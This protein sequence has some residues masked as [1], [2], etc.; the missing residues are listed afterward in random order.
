MTSRSSGESG[1]DPEAS[2]SN[3]T[4]M[5]DSHS[6]LSLSTSGGDKASRDQEN[7]PE[8]HLNLA[9]NATGAKEGTVKLRRIATSTLLGS[10]KSLQEISRVPHHEEVLLR[11]GEELGSTKSLQEL[12]LD[13]DFPTRKMPELRSRRTRHETKNKDVSHHEEVLL[14]RGEEFGSK[15]S[16]QDF[17]LVPV[18]ENVKRAILI[19]KDK[20][21]TAKMEGKIGGGGLDL[22]RTLTIEEKEEN[23]REEEAL[24]RRKLKAEKERELE[25]LRKVEMARLKERRVQRDEEIE[26]VKQKILE[27]EKAREELVEKKKA[28]EAE[29]RIE[30]NKEIV[31]EV[32]IGEEE[33]WRNTEVYMAQAEM[34][35]RTEE[36]LKKIQ[37]QETSRE[38]SHVKEGEKETEDKEK[39]TE[40]K[41]KETDD[42]E[43]ETEDK[44][45]E[46]EDKEKEDERKE[47][48]L[49]L[50]E[51]IRRR[52]RQRLEGETTL[53][54][55]NGVKEEDKDATN[56]ATEKNIEGSLTN[57]PLKEKTM[58]RG[59]QSGRGTN[60]NYDKQQNTT[61]GFDQKVKVEQI[62]H[63]SK[64]DS[65]SKQ[66][67]RDTAMASLLSGDKEKL[68]V[69]HIYRQPPTRLVV[70]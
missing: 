57:I 10:T 8:I 11:R 63:L 45:K 5:A 24:K 2:S 14:R 65:M 54:A 18:V 23:D 67:E 33:K 62:S 69:G 27:L 7:Y 49:R 19:V 47:R 13:K 52:R 25:A 30:E 1:M 59:D 46:T 38:K 37:T 9:A 70:K 56:M 6:T 61:F 16:L 36:M 53:K 68:E 58:E 41:E 60:F 64:L 29:T 22:M 50:R 43:K 42:K 26:R 4:L 20:E 40:D 35:S 44:E 28:R 3:R 12:K 51:E 15:R 39:E 17:Q 21:E 55:G 66:W 32:E 31:K 34:S 48:V